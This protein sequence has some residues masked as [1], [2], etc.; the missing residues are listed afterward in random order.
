MK[1]SNIISIFRTTQNHG[2]CVL[3]RS[4]EGLL[5]QSL[6]W[7]LRVRPTAPQPPPADQPSS[8]QIDQ[9]GHK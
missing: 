8:Q 4:L 2:F 7:T 5:H 1:L 3:Q 9:I 6:P